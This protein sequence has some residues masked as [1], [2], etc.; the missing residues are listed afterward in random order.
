MDKAGRSPIAGLVIG[1]EE[2][3]NVIRKAMGWGGPRTGGTSSYSK[4]VF[5]MHDPGRDSLVGLHAFL[6]VMHERPASVTEPV[7]GMHAI[8]TEELEAFRPRRFRDKLIVTKSHHMGG[9]ELNYAET[10]SDG[11]LGIPLYNLEDL[12]VGANALDAA[13]VAMGQAPAT[14]YGGNVLIGPGLG[15][16]DADGR[17]MP[18]ATRAAFRGLVK[19]F[20]IVC[21]H[22]GLDD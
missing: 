15:L 18:D 3:M 7:D 21:R 16:I 12:Y 14:I 9:L 13:L 19:A 22:A 5:S 10:W 17:L 6:K 1:K 20:E 11:A 8:L 2:P 4:A